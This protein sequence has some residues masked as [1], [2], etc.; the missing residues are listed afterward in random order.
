MTSIESGNGKRVVIAMSGGVD[1]SVAAAL[2]LEQG[3]EVIG[4]MLRL[5][6]EPGNASVNR[7]CTP[8]AMAL[9][10]KVAA[11]LSIP[12]YAIDVQEEFRKTVVDYFI[13]G[14]TNNITPNPCLVCNRDIRWGFLHK[15]AI[16]MG[17]EF[18][19]TGHYARIQHNGKFQLLR[20]IDH[21]K[22]QSYVLHVLNQDLLSQTKFPLGDYTKAEVRDLANRFSLPVANRKDSQD[23]C[24]LGENDY[25]SFLR[26]HVPQTQMPGPI[27]NQQGQ[28]IG[29]HQ[30]VAFYTIGQRKGLGI[31]AL[32]PLYVIEKDREQNAIIVASKKDLGRTKLIASRVNWISGSA[33]EV[34]FRA[35]VKIRYR[36]ADA[37]GIVTPISDNQIMIQFE[38]Q[39]YD[40]TPGQAA[41]IYDDDICLGGGIIT[42]I[43]PI[44]RQE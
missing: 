31:G 33:P 35:Q 2:L 9:A 3:Y 23:L 5:W 16:A 28:E 39:L 38:T 42:N 34:E 18:L 15:R 6:Q 13:E 11:K 37:W 12:F 24:F 25:R 40:I 17:A 8:D 41:V 36:A 7:C 1:S 27:L 20:A 44:S 19:A 10:R 30:G 43:T 26:R 14:Y 22:D 21:T 29:R 32:Q 4:I